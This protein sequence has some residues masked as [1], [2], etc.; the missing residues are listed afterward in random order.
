MGELALG[1]IFAEINTGY[2]CKNQQYYDLSNFLRG[3]LAA[4]FKPL[5]R[6]LAS[7]GITVNLVCPGAFLTARSRSR[8]E[9]RAKLK[10]I[11][12][13]ESLKMSEATIPAARL[14]T[15]DEIGSLVGYLASESAG[16]ITGS[17]IPVDGGLIQG[18]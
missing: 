16:Y 15:I 9:E 18:T 8:I 12:F 14:G 4:I 6:T 13:D 3:G 2:C 5:A 10:N 7:E 17:S 11:S 1:M